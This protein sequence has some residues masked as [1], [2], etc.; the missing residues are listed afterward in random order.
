M[1]VAIAGAGRVGQAIASDLLHEQHEVVMIEVEASVLEDARRR[2][3]GAQYVLADACEVHLL[4]PAELDTAD[5]AIAATGADQVNLVFSL[6]ASQEYGVPRVAARVNDP[7]NGWLFT[8]AWGVDVAVSTP[9]LL[10]SAALE[11][12]GSGALVRLQAFQ[13]GEVHLCAAQIQEGHPALDKTVR[14]LD[15]PL[16]ATVAAII[17][18]GVVVP[19]DPDQVVGIGDELLLFTETIRE[20]EVARALLGEEHVMGDIGGSQYRSAPP[21]DSS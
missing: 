13:G 8:E 20:A 18:E 6:L 1:K 16:G 2:F 3:P 21:E 14:E 12:V 15:L 10:A 5:A 9:S 4:A 11:A 7:R 19:P 17:R